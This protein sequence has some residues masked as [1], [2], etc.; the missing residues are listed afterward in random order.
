MEYSY[1]PGKFLIAK[2]PKSSTENERTTVVLENSEK[3]SI[4]V[5]QI[6]GAVARRIVYYSKKDKNVVQGTEMGFIKFGSRL[7]VFVPIDSKIHVELN[8]T[9]KGQKTVIASFK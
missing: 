2:L 5:R 8:Q 6:A 3:Q 9:T 7:D 4:L 1:N